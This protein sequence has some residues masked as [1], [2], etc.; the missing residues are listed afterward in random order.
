[1]IPLI[2]G[3]LTFY[4]VHSGGKVNNKNRIQEPEFRIQKVG[5]KRKY[6]IQETEEILNQNTGVRIQKSEGGKKKQNQNSGVREGKWCLVLTIDKANKCSAH[7][8]SSMRKA[9]Q[10]LKKH[11][12]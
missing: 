9:R 5:G 12:S 1:L 4:I 2:A 6:R 7:F 10:S 8:Q 11:F 3:N